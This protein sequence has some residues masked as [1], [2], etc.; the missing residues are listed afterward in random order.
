MRA[1][2]ERNDGK[3][4][5]NKIN[6][7]AEEG[8]II[9]KGKPN[10]A[11][12]SKQLTTYGLENII[13]L[14]STETN[15]LWTPSLWDACV[16]Y[17]FNRNGTTNQ[18]PVIWMEMALRKND[19]EITGLFK[20]IIFAK[21]KTELKELGYPSISESSI[22]QFLATIMPYLMNKLTD[23]NSW[24]L[25]NPEFIAEMEHHIKMIGYEINNYEVAMS[26]SAEGESKW[27]DIK[28]GNQYP[29]YYL[30]YK[31]G[32]LNTILNSLNNGFFIPFAVAEQGLT[33]L[34]FDR[35]LEA[36][37]KRAN[38]LR[39]NAPYIQTEEGGINLT[40]N[41]QQLKKDS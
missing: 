30:A 21:S 14:L 18:S 33:T 27:S 31:N 40:P 25:R 38:E 16:E 13:Y 5:L 4:I 9:I 8:S 20:S 36:Y 1:F 23:E 19:F 32:Y 39:K 22:M 17:I 15:Y 24:A 26:S 7:M 41:L 2:I 35:I 10:E 12:I 6:E 34:T 37:N 29:P 3:A 11:G 28:H